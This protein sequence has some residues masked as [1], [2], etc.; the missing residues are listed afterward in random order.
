MSSMEK[1]DL[2]EAVINTLNAIELNTELSPQQDYKDFIENSILTSA[3]PSHK[4][5]Y[6]SDIINTSCLIF[7]L[8][9]ILSNKVNW[10]SFLILISHI[11]PPKDIIKKLFKD[12]TIPEE[13]LDQC[14]KNI[15]NFIPHEIS[16]HYQRGYDT[17]LLDMGR[18][19]KDDSIEHIGMQLAHH[20]NLLPDIIPREVQISVHILSEFKAATLSQ[21]L[22]KSTNTIKIYYLSSCIYQENIISLINLLDSLYVSRILIFYC[23]NSTFST[24]KNTS[25]NNDD[26]IVDLFKHIYS[27]GDF[28]LWITYVNAYPCRF[29]NIQVALG[30]AL[31]TIN[32]QEVLDFYI[33]SIKLHC[34]DLEHARANSREFVRDCLSSFKLHSNSQIQA[35][36]WRKSFNTWVDWSFNKKTNEHM[37]S[38]SSSEIDY[39]VIQYF[40]SAMNNDERQD[41]IDKMQE[42]LMS[43]DEVWFDSKST[44]ISHY[45]RYIS[46][47]Q[48]PYHARNALNRPNQEIDL[49]KKFELTHSKY[50]KLL[51]GI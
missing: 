43:I 19:I 12:I 32:K 3:Y 31:A 5:I 33:D 9:K 22:L 4:S 21:L 36:C 8:Q 27:N 46:M 17:D 37:F 38:I 44:L 16:D 51:L 48:L 35:Y 10:S 42:K 28:N 39:P 14:C 49:S 20:N 30:K 25:L 18:I 11:I 41:Y 34:N 2:Y 23:I 15:M 26:F 6:F 1:I 40:M 7:T 45:Y 50:V 13:L 47:L 29:P 24:R